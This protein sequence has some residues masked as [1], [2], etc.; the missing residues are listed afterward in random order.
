LIHSRTEAHP[1]LYDV[2]DDLQPA[3][4]QRLTVT[5]KFV[6]SFIPLDNRKTSKCTLDWRI[7]STMFGAGA[8]PSIFAWTF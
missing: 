3:I 1:R 4:T 2:A 8:L 5:S 6:S 7:V